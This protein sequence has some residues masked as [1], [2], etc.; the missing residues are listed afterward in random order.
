MLDHLDL[1]R[2]SVITGIISLLPVAV[3]NL[4]TSDMLPMSTNTYFWIFPTDNFR[5]DRIVAEST[6]ERATLAQV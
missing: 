5:L 1:T 2:S 4:L 3:C 6:L